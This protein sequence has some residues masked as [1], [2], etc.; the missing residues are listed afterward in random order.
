MKRALSL[1]TVGMVTLALASPSLAVDLIGYYEFEGNFNNTTGP[2]AA[3]I[4]TQNPAQVNLIGG[5]F[6]GGGVDINDPAASGGGNTG[7]SLNIP[8]NANPNEAPQVSFGGWYN[9]QSNAGFPG[10]TAIDN[11]GWDRGIH[12]N[13]NQWGFASGGTTNNVAAAPTDEWT[14]VVGTFDK[15]ANVATLYIGDDNAATQTTT[16]ATRAD[17]GNNPGET[18]IEIGRYDNQDL[19]AL[20]DDF[21]VWS[22]ALTPDEA[23]AIRNLRLNPTLDYSP[24][25][26]ELLFHLFDAGTG[27]VEI[28]GL[29]W[30]NTSGLAGTPGQLSP[31]GSGFNLVLDSQAGTGLAAAPV[32]EP[33]TIA[34]WTLVGLMVAG[35]GW[36]KMRRQG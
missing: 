21:M 14:Y 16:S 25:D 24:A 34:I 19:D 17:G 36:R 30:S 32:P 13:N 27:E 5:G 28:D 23:N 35:F 15:T 7:G 20:V 2:I 3:A 26:A 8:F 6:R 9:L 29:I 22:V 1:V 12:L 33:S 10:V 31:D 11:G 4:P 18:Q